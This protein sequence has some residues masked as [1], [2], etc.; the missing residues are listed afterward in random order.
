[1]VINELSGHDQGC[2]RSL[3]SCRGHRDGGASLPNCK[4]VASYRTP[5]VTRHEVLG[6]PQLFPAESWLP[7][8]KH[9]R[10]LPS[11]VSFPGRATGRCPEARAVRHTDH[12]A[13]SRTRAG[14]L[15]VVRSSSGLA[16]RCEGHTVP[17]PGQVKLL[18]T[19]SRH[20]SFS[21]RLPWPRPNG[22]AGGGL[23]VASLVGRSRLQ[24][25]FST[26]RFIR[27]YITAFAK[28]ST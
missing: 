15:F 5:R 21:H 20:C 1:M 10:A 9:P 2:T 11:F 7:R 16:A 28:H 4:A 17:S 13:C 23:G 22:H 18:M 26:S 24:Q 8:P 12:G 14:V 27:E 19:I 3:D 25:G 6:L